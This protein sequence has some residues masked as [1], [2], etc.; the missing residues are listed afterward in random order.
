MTSAY[1]NNF[2]LA[3]K[4]GI[5]NNVIM[6]IAPTAARLFY[7]R[8]VFGL[9]IGVG[10][11]IAP[12][13]FIT[14]AQ[15]SIGNHSMINRFCFLDGRG[16]L[17]IGHNVN[18][19]HFTLIQTLSHDHQSPKFEDT[20]KSVKIGDHAWL[21][22]RCLVLPGVTIGEGAVV[23]AG[24]VVSKDVPPFSVVAGVPAKV[25]G[26]RNPDIDYKTSYFPY[27]DTDV[28]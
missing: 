4:W 11:N 7:L 6:K 13:C 23:G 28:H 25:I 2:T 19:S 3:L 14:G 24:A 17:E 9:K 22:A 16:G 8:K 27:L 1:A 10:T 12:H 20:A 21:G 15:I 5:L 26:T 18:I